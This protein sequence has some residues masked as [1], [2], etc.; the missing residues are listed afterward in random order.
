MSA[1]LFRSLLTEHERLV[2]TRPS[3]CASRASR[4]FWAFRADRIYRFTVDE[5]G[6]DWGD[7]Q[8]QGADVA[9]NRACE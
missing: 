1:S 3:I 2:L 9:V 8:N 7:G 4:A 6:F 5:R